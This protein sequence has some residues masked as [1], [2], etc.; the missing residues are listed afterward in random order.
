TRQGFYNHAT[1]LISR[2]AAYSLMIYHTII[3]PI[4]NKVNC[5]FFCGTAGALRREAFEEVGGWNSNSITEDSDLS[6]RLLLQGY[7]TVYLDIE[8]PSEVPHTFESFIK[9][10]MRWCYG[11]ARVFF[12][13]G[14]DILFSRNLSLAQRIMII[15]ITLANLIAPFVVLMT[16]F[17]LGGWFFGEPSLFNIQDIIDLFSRFLITAGFMVAGLITLKK[18]N[19]LEEVH[20]LILS[21]LTLGLVLSVANGIAFLRASANRGLGWF[22]T[23]KLANEEALK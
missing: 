8:T 14:Y 20:Y 9:Q 22:C 13:N 4:N 2:F 16:I 10:Q 3:M 17:G 12:D 19:R 15:F 18:R 21:S 23:P 6:V 7:K 1:N 11:N 5:V